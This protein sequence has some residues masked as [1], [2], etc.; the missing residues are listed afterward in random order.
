[1]S[2]E[3]PQCNAPLANAEQRYCYRCGYELHGSGAVG[4]AANASSAAATEPNNA[5]RTTDE[6]PAPPASEPTVATTP[7]DITLTSL[8]PDAN[9]EQS[10]TLK[11]LLPSG[12]IFDR[13]IAKVETQIGKGPRNDIVIADPAVSTSHALLRAENG[14]YTIRDVG[15]RNGTYVNGERISEIRHLRHGD[16]IGLGLT[17]LTFRLSSYSETGIIQMPELFATPP[18]P[19]AP[20]PLTEESLAQALVQSG[21]VSGADVGR[22]RAALGSRRFVQALLDERLVGDEALRDLLSRTFQLPIVSLTSEPINEEIAINFSSRLARDHR[23]FAY[24]KDGDRLLLAMVDPTHTAARDQAEQEM[25]MPALVHVARASEITEQIERFYGPKLIGVLP[26][27]EKLRFPIHQQE[28]A[29]GK[30]VHNQLVLADP[31]VSNTHAVLLFRDDC[32]TVI[33]LGSRNGTFVNGERL[34]NHARTLK[35]GDSIQLGQTVLTFRNS[36]ETVENVTATLSLEAL[37]DIRTRA[38][39]ESGLS[40]P[41]LHRLATPATP[42][43]VPN[44]VQPA[45]LVEAAAAPVVVETKNEAKEGEEEEKEEKSEKKKKKKKDDR[46]RAAYVGAASRI[47]AQVTGAILTAT[48]TIVVA[49]YLTRKPDSSTTSNNSGS[50]NFMATSGDKARFA[51]AGDPIRIRGGRFEASGGVQ[52]PDT[53]GVLFVDDGKSDTVYWMELDAAGNQVGEAKPIA[54]GVKVVNP[55]GI[56]YG[57]SFFYVVGSQSDPQAGDDNTLIRFAFDPATQTILGHAEVIPNFRSF[58]L[59]NVA[60]LKGEGER[61]G[62]EG[63]LNIEGIAWDPDPGRERLLIGL[64]APLIG[65]QAVIVPLRITDL[66]HFSAENFRFAEPRVI[67]LPLGG[68]GLR[69][70]Q[71]DSKLRSF[72]LI[73]G[74]LETQP[75]AEFKLWEW[76]GNS[77]SPPMEVAVLSSDIKPEGISNLKIGGGQ[78]ALI[79]GDSGSYV[80][81]DYLDGR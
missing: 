47:L 51:K 64:R 72:L 65:G 34:T 53:N 3:C 78:M 79:F 30:A 14:S 28:V 52:V 26:S 25:R 46:I 37:E 77:A 31:T 21:L 16:V 59:Q 54:L 11:I 70:L 45:A 42:V 6:M 32:Y 5:P 39:L 50:V 10:A 76:N 66:R 15:S 57:G 41:H 73:S 67:T 60:E 7:P 1:M 17:K 43:A 48:L 35:H 4:N 2:V 18:A 44:Q 69:D 8:D 81:L 13:E 49:Y 27:G 24:G 68:Y 38:S 71:Y 36:G 19:P 56:T 29:I 61:P 23:L 75:K 40:S 58:L 33:D 12:D 63:G 80:K 20:P 62:V 22:L 74:A 55:E 9:A